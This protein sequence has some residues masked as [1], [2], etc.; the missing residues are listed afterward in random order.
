MTYIISNSLN[1]AY[2]DS[3]NYS[4]TVSNA[5]Y[6]LLVTETTEITLDKMIMKSIEIS[7]EEFARGSCLN[8]DEFFEKLGW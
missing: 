3:Y 4:Y 6:N 7:K 5:N 1:A 2:R 8:K